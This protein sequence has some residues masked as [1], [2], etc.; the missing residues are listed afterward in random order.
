MAK[1]VLPQELYDQ[2]KNHLVHGTGGGEPTES[3][4]GPGT[5]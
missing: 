1:L 3:T 2:A 5:R 4:Y